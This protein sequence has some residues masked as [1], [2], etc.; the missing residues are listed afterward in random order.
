MKCIGCEHGDKP[1]HGDRCVWATIRITSYD[2][3]PPHEQAILD[4]YF[5]EHGKPCDI[6][7]KLKDKTAT[8]D[9]AD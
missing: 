1:S 6:V 9:V 4:A 3:R 7:I 5:A 8:S 2:L